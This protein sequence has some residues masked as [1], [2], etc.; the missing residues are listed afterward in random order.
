MTGASPKIP[1]SKDPIV[2]KATGERARIADP[3]ERGGAPG[4]E[5]F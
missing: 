3:T 1:I 5:E 4:G 2:A